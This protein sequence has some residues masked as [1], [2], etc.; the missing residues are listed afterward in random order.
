META[1]L[2]SKGQLVIPRKVRESA[3]LSAG[4]AFAVVYAQGEIR[5]RPLAQTKAGSTI[6]AVAGCLAKTT[7][8]RL[9]PLSDAQTQATIKAR[10]RAEDDATMRPAR[11]SAK[12][13]A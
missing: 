10:L 5:L 11:P 8:P 4:D 3:N 6:D 9:K 7:S 2:S 12:P 13:A 1:T